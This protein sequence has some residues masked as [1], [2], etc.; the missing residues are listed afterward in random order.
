VPSRRAT[1]FIE[2][3][4]A[5][6]NHRDWTD[7]QVATQVGISKMEIPYVVPQARADLLADDPDFF[8]KAAPE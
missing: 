1:A 5:L 4:L 7:E 3:K 6:R 8:G 2:A